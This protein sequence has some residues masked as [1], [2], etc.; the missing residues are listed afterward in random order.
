MKIDLCFHP[1]CI[2]KKKRNAIVH[3]YWNLDYEKIYRMIKEDI[4][5]FE[6]FARYII[7]Y[8]DKDS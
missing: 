6:D 7:E 3:V 4:T 2:S 5:D 8:V 1:R